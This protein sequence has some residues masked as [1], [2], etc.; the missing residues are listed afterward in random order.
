MP[1]N[2]R[3]SIIFLVLFRLRN[4]SGYASETPLFDFVTVFEV[5][6]GK[7]WGLRL[8]K[9]ALERL[10]EGWGAF[11]GMRREVEALAVRGRLYYLFLRFLLLYL[12]LRGTIYLWLFLAIII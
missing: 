12:Y 7:L 4:A 9:G 10:H 5:V 8:K 11:E 1:R 2:L 3:K 6:E